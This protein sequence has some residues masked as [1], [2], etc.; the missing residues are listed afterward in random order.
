MN[1]TTS[2]DY[3]DLLNKTNN[4]LLFARTTVKHEHCVISQRSRN[5]RGEYGEIH[6]GKFPKS[7]F[8]VFHSTE[9]LFLLIR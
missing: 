7:Q 8:L 3:I 2:S 6:L 5:I 4:P 1:I 9:K